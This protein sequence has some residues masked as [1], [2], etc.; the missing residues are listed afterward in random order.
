MGR[1]ESK[2][3][4]ATAGSILAI[5]ASGLSI[6]SAFAF[7][8]SYKYLNSFYTEIGASWALDLYSPTQI[9]QNAAPLGVAFT[10]FA[11]AI[12]NAYPHLREIRVG[13]LELAILWLASAAFYAVHLLI[14]TYWKD[15]VSHFY[16]GAIISAV[17][18]FFFS[19]TKFVKYVFKIQ[20][21][22]AAAVLLIIGVAYICYMSAD[23]LGSRR[24]KAALSNEGPAIKISL[25]GDTS[26]SDF[27][28]IRMIPYDR[29]L[30][31]L[32]PA[33][34]RLRFRVV[35]V[36]DIQVSSLRKAYP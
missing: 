16:I 9:I 24:A 20:G 11:F 29:A 2:G 35:N 4:V 10:G 12:W 30:V 25:V 14:S 26:K 27:R 22:H 13:F 19:I 5:A 7:V 17:V 1:K 15:Y 18:A 3:L 36:T 33:D 8:I 32:E 21:N 23:I 34:D 28:L 6:L 31:L